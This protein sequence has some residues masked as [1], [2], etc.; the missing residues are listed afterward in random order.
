GDAVAYVLKI[1]YPWLPGSHR[2]RRQDGDAFA[3]LANDDVLRSWQNGDVL[4]S[5]QIDR[6]PVVC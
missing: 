5:W 4:L 3:W 1:T 2:Y 6:R